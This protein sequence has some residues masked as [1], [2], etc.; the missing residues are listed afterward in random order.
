MEE[1]IRELIRAFKAAMTAHYGN[2]L[3]AVILFGSHA[4]G[5]GAADSDVDLLVVL[6][7]LGD[8]MNEIEQTGEIVAGLCL[9]YGVTISRVFIDRREWEARATV[10]LRNV[11]REMVPA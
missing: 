9:D 5:Q 3:V 6:D 1:N 4:R 11:E 7:R 2:R 10:F 8:Y